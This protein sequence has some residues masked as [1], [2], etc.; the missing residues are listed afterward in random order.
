MPFKLSKLLGIWIKLMSQ[1]PSLWP[2]RVVHCGLLLKWWWLWVVLLT[3]WAD[4]FL[5][6]CMM[7]SRAFGLNL[8]N[9]RLLMR[10][11]EDKMADLALT[12]VWVRVVASELEPVC[13]W[14]A[15]EPLRLVKAVDVATAAGI[16]DEDTEDVSGL[17]ALCCLGDES[18]LLVL[19][20]L[21]SLLVLLLFDFFF[22]VDSFEEAARVVWF[23]FSAISFSGQIICSFIWKKNQIFAFKRGVLRSKKVHHCLYD[24]RKTSFYIW[25]FTHMYFH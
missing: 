9:E 5:I 6:D 21:W 3:S 19:L 11:F 20:L 23:E 24:L 13:A 7:N 25:Y 4:V 10:V 12:A 15:F 22:V 2:L 17:E 14:K 18:L 8:G 1:I 16:S